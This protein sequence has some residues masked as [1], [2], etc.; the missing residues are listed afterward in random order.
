MNIIPFPSRTLVALERLSA[1][2]C[3]RVPSF[4]PEEGGRHEVAEHDHEPAFQATA[5]PLERRR[6]I[7][8]SGSILLTSSKGDVLKQL[9]A[10]IAREERRS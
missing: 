7:R 2:P 8:R 9:R 3:G 5:A 10:M 6:T 4:N 1:A